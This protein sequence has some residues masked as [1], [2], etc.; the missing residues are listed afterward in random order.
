MLPLDMEN[1][2]SE[3]SRVLKTGGRYL[4]TFIILK[5]ESEGLIRSGHSTLDFCYKI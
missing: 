3:I 2:L 5:S 4:I 1:Y